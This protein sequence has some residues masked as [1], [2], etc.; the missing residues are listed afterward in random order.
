M[1]DLPWLEVVYEE[2]VADQEG[3]SRRIL[4]FLDLEWDDRC[5]R[6][7]E[8]SRDVMTLSYDQ[9]RRPMYA[10]SMGRWR[11]FEAHLG[12]LREALAGA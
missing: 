7:H 3:Q 4:E 11:G 8:S 10:G 12:P 2:L 9:V 5:L 1:L 6:F